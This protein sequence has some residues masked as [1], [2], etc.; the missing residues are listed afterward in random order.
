MTT[1]KPVILTIFTVLGLAGWLAAIFE[2]LPS[3][4]VFYIQISSAVMALCAIGYGATKSLCKRVFSMDAL[5][6]IAILASIVSGEYFPATMVALMLLGGEMLEDY[7]QG[8]SSKAIQ[9]LLE[10]QPQTAI[11][12]R[13]GKEVQVKPEEV[14]IGEIILV[15]PGAKIPVDGIIEKGYASINQTSVTGESVPAEKSKGATV[16]S[17]TIVQHG[18]IYVTATAVGEKSTYGRIINLVKEAE[19]K[20][21]PIERTADKY[22]KYFTPTI[23]GIGLIVF[24][25]TQDLLRTAAVFVIACPCALILSTPAAIVA[26]IG[27]ATKKG[28][29]IR[30]GETIEKMSKVKVL[31]LDKTGTITKGKLEVTDIQSFSQYTPDQILQFAAIAEKCS[32]HPFAKAILEQ[33]LK[34]GLDVAHPEYFE[35]HP[36][37]GVCIT[38]NGSRV[39]TGNERLMQKYAIQLTQDIQNYMISQNRSTV[40]F[41][42]KEGVLLGAITLAD[43][44]RENIKEILAEVKQTGVK[45]I[46]MLTGDNKNVAQAVAENCAIDEATSDLMPAD[47]V[48]KIRNLRARGV[49]VAMVGD[50]IND[51]PALAQADV[52]IAMGL[53]GTEATIETAGIVLTSD[54]LSKLPQMFKIGKTTMT[55]IKQ[56]IAFALSVNIVGIILSSQGMISPLVASVIHESNALIVMANSLRL[57]RIK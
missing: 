56:N 23:L 10:S 15:K 1:I 52:G 13:E 4:I 49:T 25:L 57:L 53:A 17:G 51:A 44:P 29:L 36:G 6:A 27:N 42:A 19:E 2:L 16:Y 35:H 32:E 14:Q 45:Q 3:P 43:Q 50:G 39:V 54:D 47:K 20:K 8:K 48:N 18:A 38:N 31:V 30:N 9:K 5:A 24:A 11:V 37:L 7:A 12:L 28:I 21:A 46:V 34:K 40:V 22:A 33:A 41:V 26:S 55:V